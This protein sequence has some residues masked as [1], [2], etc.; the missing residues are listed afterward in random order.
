MTR[1]H[2]ERVRIRERD[3][4]VKRR[5]VVAVSATAALALV[6]FYRFLFVPY[7]NDTLWCAAGI[8]GAIG[9]FVAVVVPD[10]FFW[11][12]AALH[13]IGNTVGR[14]IFAMVLTICYG[15]LSAARGVMRRRYARL[16]VHWGEGAPDIHSAWRPKQLTAVISEADARRRPLVMMP[17]VVVSYFIRQKQYVL[18]PILLVLL[19]LGL[20]LFFL[21]TS[22]FAPFIYTLF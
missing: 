5:S 3:A 19:V 6:S 20:L 8:A 9:F 13:F 12:D 10:A 1:T 16:F 2:L 14:L 22:A 15:A 4:Q 7:A 11:L 21:Q 18:I 17:L